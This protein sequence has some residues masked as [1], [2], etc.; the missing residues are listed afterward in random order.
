MAPIQTSRRRFMMNSSRF[1]WIAAI[2]ALLVVAFLTLRW[3]TERSPD[4]TGLPI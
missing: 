1:R 2:G 4:P 3:A